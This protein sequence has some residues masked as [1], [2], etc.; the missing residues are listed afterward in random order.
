MLPLAGTNC[1]NQSSHTN[2]INDITC[3]GANIQRQLDMLSPYQLE[4]RTSLVNGDL[5]LLERKY[6]A[7]PH[8]EL[9]ERLIDMC[10]VIC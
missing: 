6:R 1:E 3:V 2:S 8:L 5:V 9:W 10:L 7:I 4:N